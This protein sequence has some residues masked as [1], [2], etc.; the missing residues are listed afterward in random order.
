M[1]SEAIVTA[2]SVKAKKPSKCFMVRLNQPRGSL[3]RIVAPIIFTTSGL[4]WSKNVLCP[5]FNDAIVVMS[6]GLELESTDREILG[7]PFLSHRLGNCDHSSLGERS[8]NHLGYCFVVFPA[9]ER[10]SS[11]WKMLFLPSANGPHD[12]IR[13]LFFWRNCWVSTC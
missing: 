7:D 8:E 1:P 10:R 5:V 12:S 4:R 11:F 6:L 13:T 9:I 3:S 2:I